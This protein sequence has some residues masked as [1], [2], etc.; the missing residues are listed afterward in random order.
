MVAPIDSTPRAA[1]SLDDARGAA[2]GRTLAFIA[3]AVVAL[4]TGLAVVD[5]LPVGVVADDSMYVILARSLA[6]GQGYRFLNV[7]GLPAATHFPPGYPA[8]LALVSFVAPP[9][10]DSVV[11]F[12]AINAAFLAIA[13]VRIATLLQRRMNVGLAWAVAAGLLTA[14]SIPLLVLSSMVLSELAFLAL[15][16]ALLPALE[17]LVDERA[18]PA[19]AIAL[20]AGIALAALVRSHGIVLLPAVLL[21]LAAKRRWRDGALVAASTVALLAP[22]Q[23]WV[24]R[25]TGAL[26]APML[27][28][29]DS[30]TAWWLRGVRDMGPSM[31]SATLAKTIPETATMLAQLF[32][33]MRAGGAHLVTLVALTVL[34]SIGVAASW[35]RMP[36]TLAFLGGYLA[37]VLVWPFATARFVWGV[38]PLLLALALLGARGALRAN[39]WSVPIRAVVAV[40]LVWVTVGYAAYEVRG[41][42]GAWWSSI[43]R[44]STAQMAPTVRWVAEHTAPGDI[45][46]T[47]SE[48]AVYLYTNRRTLPI[49]S[50]TPG[51]YLH[52]YSPRENA[53]EGLRPILDAYPVHTVVVGTSKSLDAALFLVNTPTP[54]LAAPERFP[55]GAAFTVLAR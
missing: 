28:M 34:A 42:R 44:A 12:K 22:W 14:V 2:R 17:Q 46:A 31:V 49:V 16:L 53:E 47:E 3:V 6:T 36:V 19:R 23:L 51:Q 52:D 20:G 29:Y 50:L 41:V 25:H 18:S 7:P 55:G 13:S 32:S 33:P 48:G 37:I 11:I 38:W 45:V 5:A 15:V 21:P 54:R 27:G 30:Y 24:A 4:A 35:R 1:A 9:F 43:A 39:G 8:L 26:P 40:P 10:P